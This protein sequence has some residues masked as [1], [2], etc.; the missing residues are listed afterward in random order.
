M[1]INRNARKSKGNSI[2]QEQEEDTQTRRNTRPEGER[3]RH[4]VCVFSF[5]CVTSDR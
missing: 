5:V 2:E 4:S 1:H 3:G